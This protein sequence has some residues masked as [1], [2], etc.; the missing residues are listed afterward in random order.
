MTSAVQV[1]SPSR[2]ATVRQQPLTAIESPSP[3]SSRTVAARMVSR[4]ASP[5]SSTAS[6]VPSSST[7]PVNIQVSVRGAGVMVSRTLGCSPSCAGRA[8]SRR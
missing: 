7:I 6:T 8:R 2:S 4:I 3:A 1:S 5:W